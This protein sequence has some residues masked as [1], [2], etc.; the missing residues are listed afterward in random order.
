[1]TQPL[2]LI[3]PE[4]LAELLRETV[5]EEL[6]AARPQNDD[7]PALLDRAGIAKAFGVSTETIDQWR[8]AGMPERR[9]CGGA[10]RFLLAECLAWVQSQ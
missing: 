4:Q 5:R 6:R 3:T 9:P 7:K 2:I 1:M 10:P 8:K